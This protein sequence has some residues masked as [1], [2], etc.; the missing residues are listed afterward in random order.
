MRLVFHFT[1]AIVQ[2]LINVWEKIW[3]FPMTMHQ[4]LIVCLE[5]YQNVDSLARR[6]QQKVTIKSYIKK[7][8]NKKFCF[9]SP[10]SILEL[11]TIHKLFEVTSTGITLQN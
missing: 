5:G 11:P 2:W 8:L 7:G 10:R 3:H 4:M 9:I 1:A 6:L